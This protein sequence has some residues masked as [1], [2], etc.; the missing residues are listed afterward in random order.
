MDSPARI[1]R[2]KGFPLNLRSSAIP[3]G[4]FET[5][6]ID[7]EFDMLQNELNEVIVDHKW[8]TISSGLEE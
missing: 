3:M 8:F 6:K 7:Y 1:V 4:N 5:P 2:K